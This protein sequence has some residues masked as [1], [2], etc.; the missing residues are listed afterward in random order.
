MKQKVIMV[1][2][3]IELLIVIAII[4]I[5]AS[6]LLPTLNKAR[7]VAKNIS[8]TNI[9]KQFGTAN[10]LYA[11]D[12]NSY[13]VPI[14]QYKKAWTTNPELRTLMG[15][16]A[17]QTGTVDTLTANWPARLL[18]PKSSRLNGNKDGY[19]MSVS[20]GINHSDFGATSFKMN[21]FNAYN[22]SRIRHPSIL[23]QWTDS[24]DYMVYCPGDPASYRLYGEVYTMDACAYRHNKKFNSVFYDGH[25]EAMNDVQAR[26]ISKSSYY[27][28]KSIDKSGVVVIE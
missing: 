1:F 12:N 28:W 22:I 27:Y 6:I 7:E 13:S 21:A 19:S 8:C 18:C 14:V 26:F 11:C 25:C 24:L 15:I 10:Q 16:S 9:L 20:Y 4:A 17:Y 5:L 3:L 23:I 2:T